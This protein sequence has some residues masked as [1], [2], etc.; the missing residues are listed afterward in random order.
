MAF[1]L[2]RLLGAG[3]SGVGTPPANGVALRLTPSVTGTGFGCDFVEGVDGCFYICV[4]E[5][6]VILKLDPTVQEV[7]VYAGEWDEAGYAGDGTNVSA[8]LV[9]FDHPCAIAVSSTG[10]LFIADRNNHVVRRIELGGGVNTYVGDNTQ[11]SSG[12]E[13][14]GLLGTEAKLSFPNALAMD[15]ADTLYV[16]QSGL[17][18]NWV[19]KVTSDG[20]IDS[21]DAQV[22]CAKLVALHTTDEVW[23]LP[24]GPATFL[25]RINTDGTVSLNQNAPTGNNLGGLGTNRAKS[26]LY[27]IND[28]TT[29]FASQVLEVT[30][31]STTTAVTVGNAN[32]TGAHDSSPP[33]DFSGGSASLPATATSKGG[34]RVWLDDSG[35]VFLAT[36][37]YL[38]KYSKIPS[39]YS[40]YTSPVL[41]RT[42]RAG[43][44]DDDTIAMLEAGLTT[45]TT[46]D[47]GTAAVREMTSLTAYRDT[48]YGTPTNVWVIGSG[49]S[50]NQ[51]NQIELLN[52]TNDNVIRELCRNLAGLYKADFQTRG[53]GDGALYGASA[54]RLR[55]ENKNGVYL[56]ER[57]LNGSTVND[58]GIIQAVD[59]GGKLL[60]YVAGIRDISTK[61]AA[62]VALNSS[63][64]AYSSLFSN[65]NAMLVHVTYPDSVTAPEDFTPS[66]SNCKIMRLNNVNSIQP[67]AS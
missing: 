57:W 1:S 43:F 38:F 64:V 6:H 3:S 14:D 26:K 51:S 13:G 30:G 52:S 29:D 2:M 21:T 15:S 48:G 7:T 65:C 25:H 63:N 23:V 41:L 61:G 56:V 58:Y 28:G 10:V 37:S 35:A 44:S 16:G 19:R 42:T 32:K 67:V 66:T 40:G 12:D 47:V 60:I 8:G 55:V 5:R 31:T 24:K 45:P 53:G 22:E 4:E 46:E 49:Y 20:G 50:N 18:N 59:I 39:T 54:P 11:A 36:P 9:R 33:S 17:T 34:G 62:F 27:V